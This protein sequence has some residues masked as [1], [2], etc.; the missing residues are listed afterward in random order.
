[1]AELISRA[2]GVPAPF[3]ARQLQP[4]HLRQADLVLVMTRAHRSAVVAMEPAAVRRTF[5]LLELADIASAVADAGWPADVGADA[6]ARLAALPR[7]A[8]T[9]RGRLA[10]RTEL[11]VPDP[12]RQPASRYQ[13]AFQLIRGA[14]DLLL[15]GVLLPEHGD[16]SH[17]ADEARDDEPA[18]APGV[19]P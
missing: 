8:A 5:L 13:E 9:H 1:M 11:E 10:G 7:L 6:A 4:T 14:V 19:S 2:G 15:T 12:F 17:R 18:R 3:A 16:P